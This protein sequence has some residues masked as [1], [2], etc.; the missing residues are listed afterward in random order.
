MSDHTKGRV[1]RRLARLSRE[2]DNEKTILY[3]V[4]RRMNMS[5]EEFRRRQD[6]IRRKSE[7]YAALLREAREGLADDHGAD[8]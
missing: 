4:H 3:D 1:W 6:R 2:I 8:S 7:A 5:G